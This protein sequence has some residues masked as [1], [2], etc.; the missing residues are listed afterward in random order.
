MMM[1][2]GYSNNTTKERETGP[3]Y[4][5]NEIVTKVDNE[6]VI[7]TVRECN[8]VTMDS[9]PCRSLYCLFRYCMRKLRKC[10]PEQTAKQEGGDKKLG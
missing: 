10:Y 7:A 5:G 9:S 2:Y 3:E 4:Y 6:I 1:P 8:P